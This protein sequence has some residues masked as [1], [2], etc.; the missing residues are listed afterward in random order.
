[1]G[2]VEVAYEEGRMRVDDNE[3][4]DHDIGTGASWS[5]CNVLMRANVALGV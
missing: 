3:Q 2:V 5:F 4:R 1:M